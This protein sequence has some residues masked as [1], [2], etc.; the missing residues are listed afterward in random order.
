[1]I[2]CPPED[3]KLCEKIADQG[4]VIAELPVESKLLSQNFPQRNRIISGLSFASITI[5]AG[6]KIWFI[7][8]SK[9]CT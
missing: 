4:L 2:I 1:L 5:E 7:N 9:F 8:N 6:F 3:K